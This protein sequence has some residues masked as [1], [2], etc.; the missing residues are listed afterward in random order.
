MRF[1][2]PVHFGKGRDELDKT[3]LVFHSDSLKSAIYSVGLSMFDQWNDADYF[4]N[5]F[6]ISSCFPFAKD[7]FF[8]PRPM[9][10]KNININ[11]IENDLIPKKVKKLQYLEKSVFADFINQ[12][13][14]LTIN[15][16]QITPDGVFICTGK[17]A[18]T[19]MDQNGNLSVISFYQSDVQQRVAVMPEGEE[20]QSRPYYVERIFFLDNCGLYCIADFKNPDIENQVINAFKLLSENGIGTDRTVGNGYFDFDADMD[21]FDFEMDIKTR[22]DS[23]LSL[24]LFLP[25]N[26]DHKMIDFD[27]SSWTLLKRGGYIAGSQ[28]EDFRHLRKKSVYM[29]GEGSVFKT[30]ESPESNY[31]N[32]APSWNDQRMHKVWRDGKCLMLKF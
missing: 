17:E 25:T 14:N 22:K 10:N 29:F 12:E 8:L 1:S 18:Y 28:I 27:Q 13:E 30:N 24:G 5:Q 31:V 11:G 21:V 9:I 15:K 23:Y 20:D 3:E 32:L 16:E 7:Q 26:E 4:F 6:R 19:D 2:G